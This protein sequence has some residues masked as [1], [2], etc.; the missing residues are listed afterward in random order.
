MVQDYSADHRDSPGAVRC[1]VVD[2]S[3]VLVVLAMPVVVTTGRAWFRLCRNSWRFRSC[4]SCIVV[5]V[6]VTRSDKFPAVREERLDSFIDGDV[7]VLR[8]GDFTAYCNIFRTPS[9]WT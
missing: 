2:A 3:V 7:Q 6:A 1:Q 8:R 4:S 5:D 9:A